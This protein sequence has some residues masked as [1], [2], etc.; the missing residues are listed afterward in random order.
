MER[1]LISPALGKIASGLYIA[2]ARIG[3]TPLGMV[4]SFVQQ[5]SFEP[6]MISL[7]MAPTRPLIPA[8]DGH[9]LLGL[10]VLSKENNALLKA[11][12]R[13]EVSDP[14]AGLTLTENLFG[15]PQL[16]DAWVFLACKVTRKTPAGDHILYTAEVFD[17]MIQHPGGEAMVRIRLNGFSY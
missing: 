2:T 16:A 12:S 5:C 3:E 4:C 13:P 6:P 1:E 11:F 9:G 14:F 17:G 7:A 15:I 10:H 8:L